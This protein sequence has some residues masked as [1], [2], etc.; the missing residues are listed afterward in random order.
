M[1]VYYFWKPLSKIL[2]F[3]PESIIKIFQNSLRKKIYLL[4]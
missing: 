1:N 2:Y 4:D 3:K